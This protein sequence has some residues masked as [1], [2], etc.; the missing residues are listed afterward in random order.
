[1]NPRSDQQE[2]LGGN[3]DEVG[4]PRCGEI[5]VMEGKGRLADWTAGAL[6]R[7]PDP[8]GNRITSAGHRLVEGS[9]HDDWH[10]FA[11]EWSAERI[12]WFVDGV[13]FQTVDKTPGEDPA[14]WPF[15]EGHP[16]F[17]IL[18]LALGGW[19]DNP[20]LPPDDLAPQRLYVDYVRVYQ[21]AAG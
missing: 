2:G 16:F 21:A 14:Y 9:F 19:F 12:Q 7:G 13:L 18:N 10:L 3:I 4:W 15:D 1:M 11:V 17:I 8:A 6:H 20:H 5:D